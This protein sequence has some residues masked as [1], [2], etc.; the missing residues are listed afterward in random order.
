LRADL[1]VHLTQPFEGRW[2]GF[3]VSN[4]IQ[5]IRSNFLGEFVGG[6]KKEGLMMFALSDRLKK[7]QDEI[8]KSRGY[9][10]FGEITN[11]EEK[12]F[13]TREA[14]TRLLMAR[15]GERVRSILA[16]VSQEK[17]GVRDR[18]ADAEKNGSP[19][20]KHLAAKIKNGEI[21]RI[22]ERL[23]RNKADALKQISSLEGLLKFLG[24]DPSDSNASRIISR[25]DLIDA[26]CSYAGLERSE[27]V[28]KPDEAIK[29]L[30]QE[31]NIP[32]VVVFISHLYNE[33]LEKLAAER[34]AK[35]IPEAPD[36]LQKEIGELNPE[37]IKTL[38]ADQLAMLILAGKIEVKGQNQDAIKDA[39]ISKGI[40]PKKAYELAQDICTERQLITH[41]GRK[42]VA[43][44]GQKTSWSDNPDLLSSLLM[45]G[46][47]TEE[48][49][50]AIIKNKNTTWN[51]RDIDNYYIKNILGRFK[52]KD[53][54]LSVNERKKALKNW[55]ISALVLLS[56]IQYGFL[57]DIIAPIIDE[58]QENELKKYLQ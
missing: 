45:M 14:H 23:L 43:D 55:G 13:I 35:N 38:D 24:Y 48:E 25:D 47:L 41:D 51:Y 58:Q 44:E 5:K 1:E 34:V 26:L 16:E 57:K 52:I 33:K 42:W 6:K 27:L 7:I 31:Q 18:V 12:R 36:D 39:L 53:L 32:G 10:S 8:A 20:E 50:K 40:D 49:I 30:I 2:Y 4:F 21:A 15:D 3:G 29:N 11:T 28:D 54:K 17:T 46:I 56:A 22:S 37:F 19:V 9:N